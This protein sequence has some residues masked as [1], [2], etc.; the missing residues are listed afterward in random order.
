MVRAGSTS[1]TRRQNGDAAG[2]LLWHAGWALAIALA[3]GALAA[4]GLLDAGPT[5][6]ALGAGGA[7][8]GLGAI[9]SL[10]GGPGRTAAVLSWGLA[11]AVA[12]H[13]TG[14]IAGPLAA[15]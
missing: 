5:L 6:M 11:G 2:G 3:G 13:L 4:N 7:A 14:G 1:R 10:F 8:A 15:W 12:C 9:L